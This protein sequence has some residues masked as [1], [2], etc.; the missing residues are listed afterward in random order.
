LRSFLDLAQVEAVALDLFDDGAV[1]ST[2]GSTGT[3]EDEQRRLLCVRHDRPRVLAVLL[4]TNLHDPVISDS[5]ESRVELDLELG[6]LGGVGDRGGSCGG[7]DSD[8]TKHGLS[9]VL[10]ADGSVSIGR[11]GGLSALATE[12]LERVVGEQ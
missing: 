11:V 3:E 9:V 6:G 4:R 12:V 2:V 10:N 8:A 7:A 5:A 1:E